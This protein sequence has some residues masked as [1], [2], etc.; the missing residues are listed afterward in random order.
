[1][2]SS[3]VTARFSDGRW[4]WGK[5]K[6]EFAEADQERLCSRQSRLASGLISTGFESWPRKLCGSDQIP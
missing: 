3:S 1:M 2:W 5:K 6:R 4:Y